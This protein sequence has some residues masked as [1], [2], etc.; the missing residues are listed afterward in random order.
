MTEPSITRLIQSHFAYAGRNDSISRSEVAR[1]IDLALND[2]SSPEAISALRR[3]LSARSE[4]FDDDAKPLLQRFLTSSTAYAPTAEQASEAA[5][6]I[7]LARE[8]GID[9]GEID[10]AE[11]A[12]AAKFG[13][14]VARE[15]IIGAL[16]QRTGD[17]TIDAVSWLQGEHGA[18]NGHIDRYQSVLSEHL[19]GAQLLDANFNGKLDAGDKIFSEGADGE[20]DVR[21]VGQALCDR[22]LISG[23]ICDAAQDMN[24]ASHSFET[25]ANHK[26]SSRFW[27]PEGRGSFSLRSDTSASEAMQDMFANP[28]EYGFECATAMVITYYKAMLDLVGPRDFDRVM[29]GQLRIGPWDME[30]TL[31]GA[32]QAS[33]SSSSPASEERQASL[34]PG[35]YTYFKN[36]DVSEKGRSEGWQGENVIYLGDGKYYGH[37]F[38]VTTADRMV[39]ALNSSRNEGS[40]Q[41]AS[42][43]DLQEQLSSRILGEFRP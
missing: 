22:L 17:L 31:R 5:R 13:S 15:A 33:G 41:S 3:E 16:G 38:G 34:R 25:I 39:T 7:D 14:R 4:S 32:L 24:D 30:S 40:T 10:E 18:M 26:M 36:W 43:L 37:P 42:M 11:E 6:I 35:D 20:I 27:D 23:A 19:A 2:D 9:S 21:R 12:I 8:G 29:N 1:A 28:D